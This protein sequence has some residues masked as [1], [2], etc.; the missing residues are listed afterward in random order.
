MA[1][2]TATLAPSSPGPASNWAEK[3]GTYVRDWDI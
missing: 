3:E 2:P 1:V